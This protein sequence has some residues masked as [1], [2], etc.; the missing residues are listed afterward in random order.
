MMLIRES[1]LNNE[2]V[3]VANFRNTTNDH[4][5]SGRLNRKYYPLKAMHQYSSLD[6]NYVKK[7]TQFI[8]N[9]SFRRTFSTAFL[10]GASNS[11]SQVKVLGDRQDFNASNSR[12]A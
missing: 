2:N 10:P 8:N 6:D 5:G 7:T 1:N 9:G 11:Q 3:N 4:V 12:E